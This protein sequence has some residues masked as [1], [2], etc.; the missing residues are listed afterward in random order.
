M[1]VAE[2]RCGEFQWAAVLEVQSSLPVY[3]NR[4]FKKPSVLPKRC[5]VLSSENIVLVD[6]VVISRAAANIRAGLSVNS[7]FV[8]IG[9]CEVELILIRFQDETNNGRV[10]TWQ[11]HV[12]SIHSS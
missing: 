11:D 10:A 2:R 1:S 6:P 8:Y 7:L 4:E 12:E 3:A 5:A 9:L